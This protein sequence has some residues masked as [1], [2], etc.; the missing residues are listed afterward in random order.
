M[1]KFGDVVVKSTR[2]VRD[3]NGVYDSSVYTFGFVS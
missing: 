3:E 2:V 1:F